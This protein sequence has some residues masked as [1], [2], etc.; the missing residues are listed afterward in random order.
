MFNGSNGDESFAT[1]GFEGNGRLARDVGNIVM[2]TFDVERFE[3]TAL[4][5]TDI[6]YLQDMSGSAVREIFVDLRAAEGG[7]DG[8]FDNVVVDAA[9]NGGLVTLTTEG[10]EILIS[11]AL[12]EVRVRG[13]DPTLDR[14]DVRGGDADDVI[15]ASLMPSTTV[16]MD[17]VGGGGNDT[18]L[19]G[20]GDIWMSGSHGDDVLVGGDGDDLLSGGD[21]N[22][23]LIARLGSDTLDGGEGDDLYVAGPG[24]G[25]DFTAIDFWAGEGTEDRVDLRAF[26]DFTF[27]QI[28]GMS[29]EIDGNTVIDLGSGQMTLLAVNLSSL[30][31]DDFLI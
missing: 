16:A 31:Q 14:I 5:G 29:H 7:S 9:T 19:A 4:G 22:D 26:G 27:E 3:I 17:I 20:A 12:A 13:A 6:V 30:H 28:L 23:V 8:V 1:L 18:L 15:D 10:D 11:G 24:E 21:G 25:F 2:D